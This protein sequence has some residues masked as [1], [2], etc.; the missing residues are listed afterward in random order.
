MAQAI[1][2]GDEVTTGER[3]GVV[4]DGDVK[5]SG[6][7]KGTVSVMWIGDWAM[8]PEKPETLTVINR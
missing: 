5:K 1:R 6:P 3:R 4:V 8:R 2:T 7:Y